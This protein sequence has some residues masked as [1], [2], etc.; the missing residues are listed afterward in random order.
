M[1]TTNSASMPW[2]ITG[3]SMPFGQASASFSASPRRSLVLRG[4]I[5]TEFVDEH[6]DA[7]LREVGLRVRSGCPCRKCQNGEE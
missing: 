2:L 7:F 1:S 6:Y 4:Y 5:Y 3:P